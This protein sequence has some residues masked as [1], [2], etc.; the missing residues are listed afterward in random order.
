MYYEIFQRIKF[1]EVI[2]TFC[3]V[4]YSTA[5]PRRFNS[6]LEKKMKMVFGRCKTI[7]KFTVIYGKTGE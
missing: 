1:F 6:K 2:R 7:L 3:F 5:N 4:F